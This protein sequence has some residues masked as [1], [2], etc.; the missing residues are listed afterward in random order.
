MARAA[1]L[2]DLWIPPAQIAQRP[3]AER[4]R[5]RLMVVTRGQPGFSHRRFDELPALLP[6]GCLLVRNNTRVI[7]ARLEGRLPSGRALEALL[8]GELAPGRWEAMVKGAR[9]VKP[10]DRLDFAGGAIVAR[11]VERG[12]GGTWLLEFAEP[13]TFWE[14]LHRHG[15]AP[16]PP[17]VKRNGSAAPHRDWYQTCYARVEGSIAAPTAGFHFTPAVFEALRARGIEW[18]ELTLHVGLGTFLPIENRDLERHHMHREWF[19][20]PPETCR[21]VRAARERGRPV[22][23][24]GTTTVRALESWAREGFPEGYEGWTELFIHPPFEFRAVAGLITN[25][26]QPASTLVRLVAALHG[27]EL[28]LASYKEAIAREYR[29]F[30]YGDAMCILPHP[31]PSRLAQATG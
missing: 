31:E 8:I 22:I 2:F 19:M 25:F 28:V 23:A 18:V 15:L 5:S 20:L 11:A 24:V 9:K 21:A 6:P 3:L 29:F 27:E 1:S 10:G 16:L 13:A 17:Y 26:H 12:A 7:P 14:R 30:S 4:D